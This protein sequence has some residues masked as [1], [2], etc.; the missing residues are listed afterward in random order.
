VAHRSERRIDEQLG[1]VLL[2][3]RN[4]LALVTN[5]V[6]AQHDVEVQSPSALVLRDLHIG[7]AHAQLALR[8]ANP[9]GELA[10]HLVRRAA[11]QLGGERV[12]EHDVLVVE[13]LGADRL[14]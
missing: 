9:P 5:A 11:P 13:A 8:A 3:R 7:G 4:D 12:P 6:Q 1:A 10:R 14:A 2:G